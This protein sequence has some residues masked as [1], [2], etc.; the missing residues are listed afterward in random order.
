MDKEETITTTNILLESESTTVKSSSKQEF[1][2]PHLRKFVWGFIS[3]LV[4]GIFAGC[5]LCDV[6]NIFCL[7]VP[8]LK[9]LKFMFIIC[10]AVGI[11]FHTLFAFEAHEVPT[12]GKSKYFLAHQSLLNF[13]GSFIGWSVLYFFLFIRLSN[14]DIAIGIAWE[15]MLTLFVAFVGITGYLPYVVLMGKLPGKN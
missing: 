12:A 8:P 3:G 9:L 14:V 5:V 1:G 11:S 15:D 2:E 6:M 10:A 4:I 13:A 7:S